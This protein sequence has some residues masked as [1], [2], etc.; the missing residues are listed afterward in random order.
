MLTRKHILIFL[1]ITL[2]IIA[3]IFFGREVRTMAN[4]DEPD[5]PRFAGQFAPEPP[6]FD[7]SLKVITWNIRFAEDAQTAVTELQSIPELQDADILLLQEMDEK[8]VDGIAREL[9]YNYVYYPAS[10]HS[11]HN[12]NFGNAILAKWSITDDAKI[13][14]PQANPSNE[15]RRN[16]V[17][18]TDH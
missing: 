15:Q 8:G 10:V 13:L 18:G 6:E 1:A 11:H 5:G 12:H 17:R 7:G 3:G 9:G 16:A 14:L 4:Y 2:V